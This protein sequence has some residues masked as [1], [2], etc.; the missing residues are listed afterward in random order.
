MST[1]CLRELEAVF[2]Q[3][4]NEPTVEN[5]ENFVFCTE[6]YALAIYSDDGCKKWSEN[7][8]RL[9]VNYYIQSEVTEYYRAFSEADLYISEFK[10]E[11]RIVEQIKK[12]VK[13]PTIKRMKVIH[14]LFSKSQNSTSI[15]SHLVKRILKM[16]FN[17]IKRFL[18]GLFNQEQIKAQMDFLK[19]YK[20]FGYTKNTMLTWNRMKKNDAMTHPWADKATLRWAHQNGFLYDRVEQ[21]GLTESNLN[22]FI[23]DLDYILLSPVNNSYTKW[24]EDI[25][26]LR[27]VFVPLKKYF[28][29][30][31]FHVI[32]RDGKKLFVRMPDC[33][34]HI[35]ENNAD[36]VLQ[37]LRENGELSFRPAQY[38]AGNP[39]YKF[40]Y[41]DGKYYIKEKEVS[42]RRIANILTTQ[43]RFYVVQEYNEML[44]KYEYVEND[45]VSELRAV[46]VNETVFDPKITELNLCLASGRTVYVD[47]ATGVYETGKIANWELVKEQLLE[48]VSFI[49]QLEYYAIYFKITDDGIKVQSFNPH[50]VL[51]KEGQPAKETLAFLQRKLKQKQERPRTVV[52]FKNFKKVCWNLYKKFLCAPGYRDFMLKEYT[53]GII[54]DFLHFRKTSIKQKL[55]S[56]KRGYYSFRIEQY[57]LTEDNWDKFLSDRDYHWLCPINNVYQKWI[58]D[59]MTYRHVIEPFKY[60]AP[61][62]Y[63]HIMNRN[64][65]QYAIRMIDCP[66][67]YPSTFEG[68]IDLLKDTG[69]LAVKQS[70]GEHGDGF[71][72]LSYK[73]GKYFINHDEATPETIIDKL[74]GLT[75]F[76]NV[77]EFL[78]M[79]DDLRHIYP[80][81][82]NTIRVMVLNPTGSEPYIANAYMR[83]GTGSTKMTDNIGYGG[84]F[85]KVDLETGR[86]YGAEQLKNH[87]IVPCP[88]HPDTGVFIEGYLPEWDKVKEY[89]IDICSYFG[90]L[91]YLGFDVAISNEGIRI[92]EINKY[93]DLH[94]CAFY[95]D[96]VQDFFRAKVDAK[97][98]RLHLK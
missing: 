79:H 53:N 96:V 65:E 95:G 45:S 64:G 24:I 50:P 80:G 7:A 48:V 55:W 58:D 66:E 94:R 84:V 33:P 2:H 76:Y 3:F 26:S 71:F 92:L 28:P 59:K 1:N 13:H 43:K 35:S 81:S 37:L 38:A 12:F 31:Y 69:A 16:P 57:G 44:S 46:I 52:S 9:L 29:D 42:E 4:L 60:A 30:S 75:C 56:Y 10:I 70:A 98:K 93:Q 20:Q 51:L 8:S 19:F 5:K 47:V 21:Y 67:Q 88:N 68:V 72:K 18:T 41:R 40:S 49:P 34:E 22:E 36:A 82:V 77:T 25:P 73:D 32:D 61:K 54:D 17:R 11:N 62:Y 78:T 91:E 39:I 83:I 86:Y 74:K 87:V 15:R 14:I 63:Y 85:A 97:K 90:Q 23:S 6:K 27:Y 89:L